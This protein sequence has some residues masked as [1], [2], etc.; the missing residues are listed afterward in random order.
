VPGEPPAR[1]GSGWLALAA[2]FAFFVF[3]AGRSKGVTA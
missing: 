1:G 3:R 2:V